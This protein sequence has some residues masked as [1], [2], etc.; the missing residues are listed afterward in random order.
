[1]EM[2][3]KPNSLPDHFTKYLSQLKADSSE[4]SSEVETATFLKMQSDIDE[5]KDPEIKSF[6]QATVDNY[7]NEVSMLLSYIYDTYWVE[8][9]AKQRKLLSNIPPMELLLAIEGIFASE[10]DSSAYTKALTSR[11]Y[12]LTVPEHYVG[13]TTVHNVGKQISPTKF[14]NSY[15]KFGSHR[16]K[17]VA[18]I[19]DT[20]AFLEERYS[21]DFREL[22]SQNQTSTS[23]QRN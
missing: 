9:I 11:R 23:A 22:E 4:H 19:L 10:S 6:M 12:P 14:V 15:Y 13:A 17:V 2:D 7:C 20:L 21:L 3:S 5:E 8:W 16:F 18:G 1:M